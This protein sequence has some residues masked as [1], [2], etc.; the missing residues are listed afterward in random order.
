M[1]E[2][3][4]LKLSIIVL[5]IPCVR[6]CVVKVKIQRKHLCGRVNVFLYMCSYK[7]SRAKRYCLSVH[8]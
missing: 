2:T 3:P 8:L 4:L 7:Q 6:N 1:L 5:L